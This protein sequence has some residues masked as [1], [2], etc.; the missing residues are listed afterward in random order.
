MYAWYVYGGCLCTYSIHSCC[1]VTQGIPRPSLFWVSTK[2]SV[3]GLLCYADRPE[4]MEYCFMLPRSTTCPADHLVDK[5]QPVALIALVGKRKSL[6]KPLKTKMPELRLLPRVLQLNVFKVIQVFK[7]RVS[8]WT[9]VFAEGEQVHLK[10]IQASFLRLSYF[11]KVQV[12][13]GMQATSGNGN[14]HKPFDSLNSKNLAW[15]VKNVACQVWSPDVYF[16]LVT[17][18]CKVIF[19]DTT[20]AFG[21]YK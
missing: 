20:L 9:F 3:R 1:V 15:H 16:S 7:I 2:E 13:C 12:L 6:Q 19:K 17:Q 21:R 8:S 4:H 18:I 14:R 11:A 10:S 5:V